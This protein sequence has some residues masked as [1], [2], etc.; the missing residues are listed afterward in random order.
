[1]I[2][3]TAAIVFLLAVWQPV[4][5]EFISGTNFKKAYRT[6]RKTKEQN[7]NKELAFYSKKG[8]TTEVLSE[9]RTNQ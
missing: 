6:L 9:Q 7:I 8:W 2:A 1:M 3:E 4:M 5:I